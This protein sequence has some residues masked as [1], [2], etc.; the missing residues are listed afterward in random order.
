MTLLHE[1]L[2]VEPD[3]VS[4]TNNVMEEAKNTFSKKSDHFLGQART[5]KYLVENRSNEDTADSKEIVTTV[6]DKLSYVLSNAARMYD[7]LLQKDTANTLAVTDLV[8][9]G[10]TIATG[11]PG[12][13][14]LGMETRLKA[15]REVV[16]AIPTLEPAIAWVLDQ[17]KGK[18]IY[19]APPA[20][21]MKTEKVLEHKILVAATDKHP[22]QVEK[23]TADVTVARVD[24]IRFSGMWTT[25]RK[26]EVLS[27]LDKIMAA[28]KQARMRANLVEVPKVNIGKA[29]TDYLL[30]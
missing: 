14:L 21:T 27:R 15:L 26:S 9:D 23:W 12:V 8:I 20:T 22:A 3:V 1:L 17:N 2:A 16:L 18:G 10:K 25:A 29:L 19:R 28:V 6:D 5:V 11:L 24:T 4:V 30:G 7:V 13:F